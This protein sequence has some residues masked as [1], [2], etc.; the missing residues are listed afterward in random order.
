MPIASD[1]LL[2]VSYHPAAAVIQ[3]LPA[4]AVRSYN[5]STITQASRFIFARHAEPWISKAIQEQTQRRN[6]A[7]SNTQGAG[8]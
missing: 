5:A 2:S 4:P 1:R 3:T 7:G 8:T 6:A